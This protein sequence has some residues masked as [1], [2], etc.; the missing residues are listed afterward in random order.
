MRA[1]IEATAEAVPFRDNMG[2]FRLWLSIICQRT[3]GKLIWRVSEDQARIAGP[4]RKSS[5]GADRGDL[6]LEDGFKLFKSARGRRSCELSE[7]ANHVTL[8][9]VPELVRYVGP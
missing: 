2:K 7:V 1:A 6:I 8:I 4:C 9:G 3:V 5:S